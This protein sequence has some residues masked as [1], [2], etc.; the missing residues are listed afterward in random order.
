MG[1]L[2]VQRPVKPFEEPVTD[3]DTA[4][5]EPNDAPATAS[6]GGDASREQRRVELEALFDDWAKRREDEL[7]LKPAPEGSDGPRRSRDPVV[8]RGAFSALILLMS[9]GLMYFT[10]DDFSYWLGAPEQPQDLGD[11]S[12]HYRDGKKSLEVTSNSYVKVRGMFMTHEL[13]AVGKD[14][15]GDE[16]DAADNSSRK[17]FIC[18]LFDIVVQTTRPLPEKAWSRNVEIDGAY[19]DL[20]N[21]RRAFPQDL[22]VTADAE[23]RLFKLSEAPSW[24]RTIVERWYLQQLR[25]SVDRERT[26]ILMD[27]ETPDK[28]AKYAYF[29]GFAVIAPII[30][31]F[32]LF[33]SLR[34][35]KKALEAIASSSDDKG[36][37]PA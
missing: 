18:P 9:A 20:I 29:W 5:A 3:K 10:Y 7:T 25:V 19:V 36:P 35:R 12:Q 14:D 16:V 4:P 1:P 34:R 23:G 37:A 26:L 24:A 28:Y 21:R 6:E 32:L 22:T 15:K 33:R 8:W 30:P 31:L 2:H 17:Y 11:V 13:Q 27:G